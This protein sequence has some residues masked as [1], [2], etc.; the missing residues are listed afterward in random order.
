MADTISLLV[1]AVVTDGQGRILLTAHEPSWKMHLPDGSPRF[2]E[3]LRQALTRSFNED[4]GVPLIPGDLP[5][6]ITETIAR[7]GVSHYVILHY[8][9]ALGPAPMAPKAG[10]RHGFFTEAD[11]RALSLL[12]TTR[13]TLEDVL[14]WKAL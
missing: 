2:G 6:R 12:S 14:G 4:L 7:G 1:S 8:R 13:Q 5:V 3:S 10:L 9:C 11:A